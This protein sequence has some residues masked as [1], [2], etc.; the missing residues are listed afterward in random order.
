[1]DIMALGACHLTKT[2]RMHGGHEELLLLLL[3]ALETNIRLGLI[4][5]DRISGDVDSV[6]TGTGN[7][8]ALMG[9]AF[10]CDML[11]IMMAGQAHPVLLL[12]RFI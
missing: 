8:T 7:V 5:E 6:T 9:T 10:P 2:H 3:V 4:R 11:V 12:D 1:M